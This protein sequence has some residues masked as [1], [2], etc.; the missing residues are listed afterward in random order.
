MTASGQV[1]PGIRVHRADNCNEG[2]RRRKD[3]SCRSSSSCTAN[4]F[5]LMCSRKRIGQNSFPNLIYVIL[6]SFMVFCQELHNP[7]RNYENQI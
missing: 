4:N 5:G 3:G 1:P 6:K 7:K 2:K